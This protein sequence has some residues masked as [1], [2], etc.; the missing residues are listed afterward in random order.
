[1]KRFQPTILY[2]ETGRHCER[3]PAIAIADHSGPAR[4]INLWS[5][6]VTE[7]IGHCVMDFSWIALSSLS[8]CSRFDKTR[9]LPVFAV[10]VPIEN[11]SRVLK[12]R[13]MSIAEKSSSRTARSVRSPHIKVTKYDVA[14]SA[15]STSA[16]FAVLT[17]I[18]MICIWLANMLP[19]PQKKQVIMLPPGDGGYEDGDP[20][21]TPN[22]ESPED[23][24]LKIR[25]WRTKK[26][27]S[28]NW[29]KSLSRSSMSPTTQSAIVAP[30]ESSDSKNS[31][32]PAVPTEPGADHWEPE[33]VVAVA[34]NANSDGSLNSQ[35]RAI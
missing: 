16:L 12:G 17:L 24:S 22:V 18:V 1:M 14:V 6:L 21:A 15:L 3:Q 9:R 31:G 29:K 34:R 8:E 5:H 10:P 20:N 33:V 25:H 35:T 27:T 13:P 30:N 7:A 11:L 26:Q 19:S 4:L 28:L 2:G 32:I 23:A